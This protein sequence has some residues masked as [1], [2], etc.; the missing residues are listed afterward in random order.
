ML[1]NTGY[2]WLYYNFDILM[3]ELAEKMSQLE[4]EIKS[5]ISIIEVGLKL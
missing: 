2:L 3:S 5:V 1:N 4:E